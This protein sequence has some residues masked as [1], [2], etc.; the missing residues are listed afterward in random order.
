MSGALFTRI[1]KGGQITQEWLT[2][3][4]IYHILDTHRQQANIAP[5]APHDL[6]RTFAGDL[7]DA[8]VDA[9]GRVARG[10]E[11]PWFLWLPQ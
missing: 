5:F 2:D 11:C 9:D 6:R 4:G 1:T 7:L 10:R 8:G 3:Q